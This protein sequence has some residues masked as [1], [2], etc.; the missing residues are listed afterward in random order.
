MTNQ[1]EAYDT[2]MGALFNLTNAA[3]FE[4]VAAVMDCSEAVFAVV[5][6]TTRE[7]SCQSAAQATRLLAGIQS[8]VE[9]AESCLDFQLAEVLRQY[10]SAGFQ[11]VRSS[12]R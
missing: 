3:P 10:R 2:A 6:A 7:A 5:E 1:R 8:H 4:V 9:H 11:L 12:V